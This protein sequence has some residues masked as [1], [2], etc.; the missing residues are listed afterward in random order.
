[1]RFTMKISNSK[2]IQKI[3]IYIYIL[4]RV[5]NSNFKKMD[6]LADHKFN[7]IKNAMN[8]GVSTGV[9]LICKKKS[10]EKSRTTI[11]TFFFNFFPTQAIE[12]VVLSIFSHLYTHFITWMNLLFSFE[13]CHVKN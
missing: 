7:F 5:E 3:S 2:K 9:R 11:S 13:L 1:M 6:G 12:S 4:Q 10:K 8:K